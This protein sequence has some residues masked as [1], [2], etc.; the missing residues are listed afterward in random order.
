M[1]QCREYTFASRLLLLSVGGEFAEQ[2]RTEDALA[3]GAL[4]AL[5][6]WAAFVDVWFVRFA[7]F[8]SVRRRD[9]ALHTMSFF[10]LKIVCDLFAMQRR[11]QETTRVIKRASRCTSQ[12]ALIRKSAPVLETGADSL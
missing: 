9:F 4:M 1:R 6:Q 10:A 3:D 5:R 7:H 12:L 2:L 11:G 8:L